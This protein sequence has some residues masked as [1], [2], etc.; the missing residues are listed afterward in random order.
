MYTLAEEFSNCYDYILRLLG[1]LDLFG[2]IFYPCEI[3]LTKFFNL[4]KKKQ[5]TKKIKLAASQYRENNK[6]TNQ[7]ISCQIKYFLII[8]KRREERKHVSE[9]QI[10]LH[11]KSF[12]NNDN[13]QNL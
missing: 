2:K 4:P 6:M 10:M 9:R 11:V 13:V 7:L 8:G 12:Q 1:F 3:I 5:Y